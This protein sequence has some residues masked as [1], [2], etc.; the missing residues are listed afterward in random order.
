MFA[1]PVW[2]RAGDVV[3]P[4]PV[5]QN[6]PPSSYAVA[7][8]L[9][10]QPGSIL[11]LAGLT[12]LRGVFILPGLWVGTKLTKAELSLLQL[13]ALALASSVTISLGMVAYY[14]VLQRVPR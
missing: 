1:Q 14:A 10:G 4:V 6:A 2:Q 9:E 8:V 11:R 5:E 13:L 7:G 12:A 3:P